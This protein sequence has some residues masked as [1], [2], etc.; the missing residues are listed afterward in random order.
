MKTWLPPGPVREYL[1]AWPVGT[2]RD[3]NEVQEALWALEPPGQ[4]QSAYTCHRLVDERFLDDVRESRPPRVI[5]LDK[6][7]PPYKP[8]PRAYTGD[9]PWSLNEHWA[10]MQ[11]HPAFIA[12]KIACDLQGTT[13]Y[14]FQHYYT[15]VTT[16]SG[17][18][19][20]RESLRI[21]CRTGELGGV[22]SD[23]RWLFLTPVGMRMVCAE[24]RVV[25]V[26]DG[27][28]FVRFDPMH[29]DYAR[30]EVDAWLQLGAFARRLSDV[31]SWAASAP[32]QK[33]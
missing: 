2:E 26:F 12:S 11:D 6:P 23:L 32:R 31:R 15:L 9:F 24:L 30:E 3:R 7:C 19:N 21:Y 29:D 10:R 4:Y 18:A 13:W 17:L 25:P 8:R 1:N 28:E 22:S 5:R 16:R 33:R 14:G 20:V 27:S